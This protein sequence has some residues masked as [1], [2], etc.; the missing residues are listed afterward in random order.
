[1][2]DKKFIEAQKYFL[3]ALPYSKDNYLQEA[4]YLYVS[5]KLQIY[6]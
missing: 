3:Y 6:F 1:M 4:Y 5:I 2:N